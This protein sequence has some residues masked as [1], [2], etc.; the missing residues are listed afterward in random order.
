MTVWVVEDNNGW[1]L[2]SAEKWKCQHYID[3]CNLKVIS[4]KENDKYDLK[5]DE[6]IVRLK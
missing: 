4:N 1:A 6:C 5:D 3:R 2:V